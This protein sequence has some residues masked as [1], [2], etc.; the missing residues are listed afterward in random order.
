MLLWRIAVPRERLQ[1]ATI[2]AYARLVRDVWDY[3]E[4]VQPI[5]SAEAKTAIPDDAAS[6]LEWSRNSYPLSKVRHDLGI[7]ER[8][9]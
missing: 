3:I 2:I 4:V 1:T 8:K 5:S 7:K 6:A 9:Q